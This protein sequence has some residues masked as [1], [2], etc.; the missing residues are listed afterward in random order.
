MCQSK[1]AVVSAFLLWLQ[2]LQGLR[3]CPRPPT[4]GR[5]TTNSWSSRL[6]TP[7][8]KQGLR[9]THRLTRA[10][11]HLEPPTSS[12]TEPGLG[13]QVSLVQ[14]AKG[15]SLP[16]WALWP[17]QTAPSLN[18]LPYPLRVFLCW[19]SCGSG[20]RRDLIE[21]QGMLMVRQSIP[22]PKCWGPPSIETAL[23]WVPSTLA[24]TAQKNLRLVTSVSSHRLQEL[25]R[26]HVQDTFSVCAAAMA[27]E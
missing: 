12:G 6:T 4:L 24:S 7:T 1:Q 23:L 14:P 10:P 11:G 3:A 13:V 16:P 9:A 21:T 18:F 15:S 27:W 26:Q 25:F 19:S 17:P 8:K 2:P 20:N 5:S 22:A